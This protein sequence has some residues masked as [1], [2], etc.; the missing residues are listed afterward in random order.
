MT[1]DRLNDAAAKW[2][3]QDINAKHEVVEQLRDLLSCA[4]YSDKERRALQAA[5]NLLAESQKASQ[6]I[7]KTRKDRRSSFWLK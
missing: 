7:T 6:P 4:V 2:R 3:R 1:R 5:I